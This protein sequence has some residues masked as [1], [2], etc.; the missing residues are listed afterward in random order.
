M[1][2][3]GLSKTADGL[4]LGMA[5][6]SPR[7]AGERKYSAARRV[8]AHCGDGDQSAGAV[9]FLRDDLKTAPLRL[10]RSKPARGSIAENYQLAFFTPGISPLYASSRKQIRQMP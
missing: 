3:L 6:A 9:I 5:G 10:L 7:Y 2:S 1:I 8:D 4:Y